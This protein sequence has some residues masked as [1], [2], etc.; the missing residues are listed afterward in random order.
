[1]EENGSSAWAVLLVALTVAAASGGGV[2]AQ[3]ANG[4][5]AMV[6]PYSSRL[7]GWDLRAVGAY[8]A[9]WDADKPLIWLQ[10][11][12]WAAFYGPVGP[13]DDASCALCL[14]V[15]NE[16]TGAQVRVRILD[17]CAFGGLGLDPEAF[18]QV[19]TDGHGVVN[20]KLSVSY[21]FV[22]CQD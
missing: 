5:T 3:Q 19:D 12:Y 8:C 21:Q 18:V 7:A 15:V 2:A 17:K 14:Q 20:G 1:M 9:T 11:Y 4:V 6:T 10:K 13:Q 22:E 16:A